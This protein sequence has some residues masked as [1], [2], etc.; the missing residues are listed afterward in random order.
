M[1]DEI[2]YPLITKKTSTPTILPK[3]EIQYENIT[4]IASTALK[5]SISGRY[6][7]KFLLV[8]LI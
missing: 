1:M 7:K 5:P 8:N 4:A 6:L 3:F 2:K